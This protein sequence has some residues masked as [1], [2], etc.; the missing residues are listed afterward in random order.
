MIT[1]ILTAV[2][3]VPL[4]L[5]VIYLLPSPFF[6]AAVALICAVAAYEL[7]YRSGIVK[8]ALLC[9]LSVV[10]AAAVPL[11]VALDALSGFF[12]AFAFAAVFAMFFA[13]LLNY[14]KISLVMVLS[15]I[16]AGVILPV[17][18]SVILLIFNMQNGKILVLVPFLAAWMT[19][20]GA[21]F[22]GLA[23]GRHKLCPNISPKKTVEGAVGGVVFCALAFFVFGII[24]SRFGI[25]ANSLKLVLMALV[26]SFLAQTG[27]LSFSIIKREYNIKDYGNVFPGHGGVLDRFDS[28]MFTVPATYI[29]L[30]L[31]GGIM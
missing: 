1:R 20:T 2:V 7:T 10:S 8:S 24:L 19:D 30:S 23:L 9:A 29:L 5:A 27:D 12:F 4:F 17:F 31:M 15:S 26:L 14:G 18:F 6:M 21:Y 3:A 28:A 11:F 16:F 13:W 25:A 22:S